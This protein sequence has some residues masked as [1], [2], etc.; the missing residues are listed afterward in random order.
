MAFVL[1]DETGLDDANAYISVDEFQAYWSDRGFKHNTFSDKQIETAIVKATDFIESRFRTKFLGRR[2]FDGQALS[3]PRLGLFDSDGEK[4]EGLPTRLK[5]ATAEYAK[6][7]LTEELLP[8]PTF[9]ATGNT[10]RR[11]REKGGP[12]ETETEY[13]VGG[14]SPT[15]LYP[16]ADSL[17]K[18]YVRGVGLGRSIRA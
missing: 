4:I 18:E 15:P 5:S 13:Q 12:I 11:V 17:L 2:E 6:R 1:E 10:A 8:D 7:A 9:D 16:T 14:T 3:F